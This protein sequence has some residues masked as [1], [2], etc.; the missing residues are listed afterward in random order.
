MPPS[1]CSTKQEVYERSHCGTSVS[2]THNRCYVAYSRS[3]TTFKE[4]VEQEMHGS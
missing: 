2:R 3:R 4:C 1:L